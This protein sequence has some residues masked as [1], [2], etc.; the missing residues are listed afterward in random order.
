[1]D[2]RRFFLSEKYNDDLRYPARLTEIF[3]PQKAAQMWASLEEQEELRIAYEEGQEERN[4]AYVRYPGD[5]EYGIQKGNPPSSRELDAEVERAAGRY[6][7]VWELE[8]MR[9]RYEAGEL[10]PGLEDYEPPP[11]S[12]QWHR[13]HS[14]Y[15]RDFYWETEHPE[16]CTDLQLRAAHIAWLKTPEGQR[17]QEGYERECEDD[18]R[19]EP[20]SQAGRPGE[21]RIIVDPRLAGD[22]VRIPDPYDDWTPWSQY[23]PQTERAE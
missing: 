23:W 21:L 2:L 18:L 7:E 19:P 20:G 3:R 15:E 6:P 14:G 22:A 4:R 9:A 13:D 16:L 8:E 17:E 5:C 1:M 12:D 10:D 11:W